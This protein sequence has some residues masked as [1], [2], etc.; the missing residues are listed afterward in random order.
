MVV[1][2]LLEEGLLSYI[3]SRRGVMSDSR[4]SLMLSLLVLILP[5]PSISVSQSMSGCGLLLLV[6]AFV[7]LRLPDLF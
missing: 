3:V 4:V 7:T 2:L 6:Y 5:Q 1:M